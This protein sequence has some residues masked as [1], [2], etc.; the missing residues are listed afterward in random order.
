VWL[1]V[2][3]GSAGGLRAWPVGG[4]GAVVNAPDLSRLLALLT[5]QPDFIVVDGAGDA[6]PVESPATIADLAA[7]VAR[8][9]LAGA[10]CAVLPRLVLGGV[11]LSGVARLAGAL[12]QMQ[13]ER[14][15]ARAQHVCMIGRDIEWAHAVEGRIGRLRRFPAAARLEALLGDAAVHDAGGV[16]EDDD[17]AFERGLSLV[18]DGGDMEPRIAEVLKEAASGARRGGALGAMLAGVLAGADTAMGL[19]MGRLGGPVALAGALDP[20]YALTAQRYATALGRFG[21]AVR[22]LD[23]LA[24]FMGGC[25]TLIQACGII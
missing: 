24:G 23:P 15:A 9:D 20:G 14:P 10:S 4:G 3:A 17:V 21:V 22:R 25:R 5:D 6:T 11:A 13:T 8:R 12:Q 1:A 19:K 16:D 7:G 2:D 18:E